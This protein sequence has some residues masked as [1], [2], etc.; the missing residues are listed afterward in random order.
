MVNNVCVCNG[1]INYLL[2]IWTRS[3]PL[4]IPL[5]DLAYGV[6]LQT[7]E[8][9]I[10]LSLLIPALS[11]SLTVTPLGSAHMSISF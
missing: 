5:A 3:S 7:L 2:D 4:R 9:S 6:R 11:L 10:G 1:D 8:V